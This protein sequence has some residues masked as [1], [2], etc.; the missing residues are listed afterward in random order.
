MDENKTLPAFGWKTAWEIQ[1]RGKPLIKL[2]LE[3]Q[4]VR[5]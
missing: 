3:K 5:T 2:V 4:F 1:A